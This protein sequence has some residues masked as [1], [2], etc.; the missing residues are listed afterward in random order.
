MNNT[1]NTENK[2]KQ[3][4]VEI[5]RYEELEETKKEIVKGKIRTAICA[6]TFVIG[7]IG[8]VEFPWMAFMGVV[9]VHEL[10]RL[11]EALEKKAGIEKAIPLEEARKKALQEAEESN[12]EES[13]EGG[14]K[15]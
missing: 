5:T 6:I 10:Y 7:L 13:N 15:K 14:I 3:K 9:S 1:E 12:K 11:I 4:V 2:N 8:K